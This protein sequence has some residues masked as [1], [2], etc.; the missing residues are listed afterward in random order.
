MI[1]SLATIE[2]KS[3]SHCKHCTIKY[4]EMYRYLMARHMEVTW[5][6]PKFRECQEIKCMHR[7]LIPSPFVLRSPQ[8][9]FM[10][11]SWRSCGKDLYRWYVGF[12]TASKGLVMLSQSKHWSS[13]CRVCRACSASPVIRRCQLLF[14]KSRRRGERTTDWYQRWQLSEHTVEFLIIRTK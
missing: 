6:Y 5:Y 3:C 8:L 1:L 12:S 11:G 7:Q 2:S 9:S 14:K 4:T 10:S 13:G